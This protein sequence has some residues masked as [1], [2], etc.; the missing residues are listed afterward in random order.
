MS[1]IYACRRTGIELG[2]IQ[3]TF[4]PFYWNSGLRPRHLEVARLFHD[5]YR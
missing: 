1:R 2:A 3:S 4:D 5:Y